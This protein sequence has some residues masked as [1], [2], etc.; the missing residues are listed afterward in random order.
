MIRRIKLPG[1]IVIILL[2]AGIIYGINQVVVKVLVESTEP[3]EPNEK[4][5]DSSVYPGLSIKTKTKETDLYTLSV[6]QPY[7]DN[8]QINKSINEW[9]D[10]QKKEFTSGIKESKNMLEENDFRAH[11]NIQAEPEKIADKIYTLEFKAYQ[12]TGEANG[13]TKMKLFVID[14]N[15]NKLLQLDDIFQLNEESIKNIQKLIMKELH[16]NQ[17]ISFYIFDDLAKEALKD[18]DKW[19]WSVDRDKVTF[20][21]DECEISAGAAG[22]IEVKIPMEKIKPYLNEKFAK[23]IDV[24]IPE[25]DNSKEEEQYSEDNVTLDPNGKYVA[26]TFDDGPRPDVTPRILDTLKKHD[27]KATFFMLGSQVEYYPSLANKVEEAGHDIGNHTMNHQDLSILDSNKIK[28]EAQKSSRIIEKATGQKPTLLRPPYGA[29]NDSVKRVTKEM[30]VPMVMWSVD[31]LDWKSR[32]AAAVNE[33]VM[34]N[35]APGS[36]VLL[37]DIHP[38]T[39]D[40]LPQL[41]SSLEEQGYQMVTVSQLL[42]LWDEKGVGP[43][44]G[45]ID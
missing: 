27:A 29:W 43:Y 33:E 10:Q 20:Y 37:H 21:F 24:K 22:A 17:K 32:N 23:K 16:S 19:K 25:K 6:S 15:Q 14:L 12:I 38:S 2:L 36:I 1:W 42:E 26:L 18:P 28:E 9:I 44:Y 7:T 35:V 31:S 40:A 39:A 5:I 8:E 4:I 45:K 3:N 34:S 11:L 30:G 41:L 13:M